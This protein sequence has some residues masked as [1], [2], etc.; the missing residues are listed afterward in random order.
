MSWKTR[1]EAFAVRVYEVLLDP[2]VWPLRPRIRGL[3]RELGFERILDIASATG[4]QCRM[5]GR[6]GISATGIDLS[7]PMVEAARRRGG[8]NTQYVVGSAFALPFEDGAFDAATL[9]LAIHE[10]TEDERGVMLNEARRV[11]RPGGYLVIAD[12]RR[13]R[14]ASIHLPWLL[15]RLVESVAGGTHRAGFLDFVERGGLAG[16][17]E[18]HRLSPDREAASHFGTIGIVVVRRAGQDVLV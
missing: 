8:R 9:L 3:C 7:V 4:A 2:L 12:Y 6:A 14:R 10:H 15:I 17:V 18:R 13:P 1:Y 16:L 11:V 5:L